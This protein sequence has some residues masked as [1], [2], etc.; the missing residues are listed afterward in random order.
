M[1]D[2]LEDKR[3]EKR[4]M[5]DLDNDAAQCVDSEEGEVLGELLC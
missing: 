2:D 5:K 4:E 3:R 1:V